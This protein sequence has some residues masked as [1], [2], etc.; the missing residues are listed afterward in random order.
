MCVG[1][2]ESESAEYRGVAREW[3]VVHRNASLQPLAWRLVR[4][5]GWA[6]GMRSGLFQ[7][8]PEAGS[9]ATGGGHHVAGAEQRSIAVTHNELQFRQIPE[10]RG[11]VVK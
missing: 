11:V 4:F 1:G 8:S 2:G 9:I 5:M 3:R 6:E 10:M 7:H